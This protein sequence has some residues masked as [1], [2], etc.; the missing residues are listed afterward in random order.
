MLLSV[1]RCFFSHAPY[2]VCEAADRADMF[3]K[4]TVKQTVD[5]VCSAYLVGYDFSIMERVCY[6]VSNNN[7]KER[8]ILK[9]DSLQ[10]M[11]SGMDTVLSQLSNVVFR[12]LDP[13][14]AYKYICGA[15]VMAA[16]NEP[17]CGG[18]LTV[19]TL[20]PN[21][22]PIKDSSILIDRMITHQFPT[23]NKDKHLLFFSNC[24]HLFINYSVLQDHF[25]NDYACGK[26]THLWHSDE[27]PKVKEVR[28]GIFITGCGSTERHTQLFE[29]LESEAPYNVC[30]AADRADMF[31]KQTVDIC[32]DTVLSQLSNVVFRDLDPVTAYKYICGALVMA[33]VNE[34]TCGGA[35]TVWTLH[36]NCPPIK[37]SSILIDRMITHQ[38]P[39]LNKDKHLL[40]FSNCSH[41]FINYSVLQD[42]F[43]NDYGHPLECAPSCLGYISKNWTCFV[44]MMVEKIWK[45]DL[46]DDYFGR[47][48]AFDSHDPKRV[49]FVNLPNCG[50]KSTN[51]LVMEA[52]YDN[53]RDFVLMVCW[54]RHGFRML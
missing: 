44:A 18:A 23:L 40:F 42:H 10:V 48:S 43:E 24:S 4:Q 22:P 33:A 14:T 8:F 13:V 39:T 15:L 37:D 2:N 3:L 51:V 7:S 49:R 53:L 45:R 6:K 38:F 35:L 47:C 17:T 36:P 50:I 9:N 28:P 32:M 34:P 31:L 25:E 20:H 5:I 27:I 16:V 46:K 52:T 41:L 11:G 29:W 54:S 19:W 12:D 21:C 1:T 30:K 26:I